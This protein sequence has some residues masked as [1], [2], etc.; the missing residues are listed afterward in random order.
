MPPR[1]GNTPTLLASILNTTLADNGGPT[2]THALVSGSPAINAADPLFTDTLP[3]NG[4]ALRRDQRRY[5]L[6]AGDD[7]RD[8]GA[9]EFGGIPPA[10]PFRPD[11]SVGPPPATAA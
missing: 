6:A 9:F 1:D 8:I 11:R 2:Q 4:T 5:L 7:R 10:A 3:L